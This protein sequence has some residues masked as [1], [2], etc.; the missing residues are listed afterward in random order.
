M[1]R[2]TTLWAVVVLSGCALFTSWDDLARGWTGKN[3][4][5]ITALWGEPDR[6]TKLDDGIREYEYHL[7]KLDPSCFHYW[8]VN[9]EGVITGY[10]YKG[11]CRPIG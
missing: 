9:S 8:L 6:I 5:R 11:Y 7:K 10:R 1:D 4:S 3:I 2:I